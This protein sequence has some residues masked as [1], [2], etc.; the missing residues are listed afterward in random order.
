MR[1]WSSQIYIEL[2]YGINGKK[3]ENEKSSSKHILS[4]HDKKKNR[5]ATNTRPHILP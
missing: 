1:A 4:G 3:I 5:K 2:L